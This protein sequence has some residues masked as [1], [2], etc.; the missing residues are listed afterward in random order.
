MTTRRKTSKAVCLRLDIVALPKGWRSGS[1][2]LFSPGRGLGWH[3]F[4]RIALIYHPD[5]G[6]L[7]DNAFVIRL[8]MRT[9][10]FENEQSSFCNT[11]LFGIYTVSLEPVKTSEAIPVVA[12]AE[13]SRDASVVC[14]QR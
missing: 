4:T 1:S 7:F 14:R 12:I 2:T 3:R 10:S 5:N 9:P 13:S 8:V 11:D 6:Y